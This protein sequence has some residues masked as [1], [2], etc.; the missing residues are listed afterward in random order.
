MKHKPRKSK[1]K[2]TIQKSQT[3]V[4]AERPAEKD[5]PKAAKGIYTEYLDRQMTNEQLAK[6]RNINFKE[7]QN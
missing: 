7:Y 5:S 4:S 1:P 6:E 3:P 2:Q